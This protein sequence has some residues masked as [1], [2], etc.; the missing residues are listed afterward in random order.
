MTIRSQRLLLAMLLALSSCFRPD[1]PDGTHVF[2]YNEANGISSLDPAFARNLE[3]MWAVN[4][5]FDG[6]LRLGDDLSIEPCIAHEY[7]V[8]D[9]GLTYTFF[10]R[11]DVY[12]HDHEVFD[13]G[14]GRRLVAQDVVYSFS[15]ITDQALAS[16]GKWI[17]DRL[18]P[19]AF[20][21]TAPSDSVVHI[22]LAE[23]FP[24]FPGLLTTQYASVVAR[25]AVERYGPDFRSNP[26]GSGPFRFA[27]WLE[28]VALIL[29]KHDQYWERDANGRQLPYLDAVKITFVRDMTAEYLG[30][31]QGRYHFMSGIHPAYKDELLTSVGTL[32]ELYD[33]RIHLATT[34]FIKTDY[35]GILTDDELLRNHP[36]RDVRV[37]QAL[38]HA[39][40]RQKMVRYL[41]N[42][43]V[44]PAMAGF[45]PRGLPSFDAEA[46]YGLPYSPSRSLE[47][48]KEAGFP[49]GAGLPVISIA[50]TSDYADLCEFLQ[51][52]WSKV[53]VQVKV[54]VM[55]G[56]V[57]RERVAR[58]QE[59]LFRKSWLADYP[60]EENFFLL[61]NSRNFAPEGPNYTH[62][63]NHAFDS[64]FDHAMTLSNDQDRRR[65]YR[66]L[67]SIIATDVPVIPLYYDRV[68]HFIRN[69]VKG[70]S[71][72]PVNML[73]L[74][75]VEITQP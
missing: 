62:Y 59:L 28:D 73:D 60:D 20:A 50:T 12:F 54:D 38:V 57:H 56:T 33:D 1:R 71:T 14:V 72:N 61:F 74:R 32:R 68:T 11:S 55:A 8:S 13:N 47:L 30:L 18:A 37:R 41:R 43:S 65:E 23:P 66:K 9:D 70:F 19:G 4:Q 36:L 16:P 31:L 5:L 46:T 53:G 22:R 29:H 25:E 27:F 44:S 24:P 49:G 40:D 3:N 52:E 75:H 58:S 42:N 7:H 15:R 63:R 45:V 35:I 69:E 10:L 67:D 48:L 39:T 6:L 21:V 34:P 17:F 2:N 51:H 26:V 64:I